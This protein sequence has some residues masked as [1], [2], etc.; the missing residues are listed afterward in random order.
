MNTTVNW[1]S[2]GVAADLTSSQPM[3]NGI[4]Y[5][6]VLSECSVFLFVRHASLMLFWLYPPL[7]NSFSTDLSVGLEMNVLK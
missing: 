4:G 6:L 2:N 7:S 3:I 1:M 5:Y